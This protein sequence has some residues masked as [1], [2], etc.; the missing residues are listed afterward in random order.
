MTRSRFRWMLAAYCL[1][2][3]AAAIA[4]W[5]PQYSQAL[6]DAYAAEPMPWSADSVAMGYALAVALPYLL[7]AA[8]G[9]Q[10]ATIAGLCLFKRWARSLSL[11][12]TVAGLLLVPFAGATVAW[13]LESALWEASTLLWGAILAAA[14]W[15][16]VRTAF[17]DGDTSAHAEM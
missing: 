1:A 12:L 5:F 7:I 8:L 6:V 15:S 17:G 2:F 14:Y 10:V 11:W 3:V 13:G 4:T 9:V 16:P